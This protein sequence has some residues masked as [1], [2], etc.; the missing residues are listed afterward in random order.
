[1][2]YPQGA[3]ESSCHTLSNP[4]PHSHCSSA[5]VL[6]PVGFFHFGVSGQQIAAM[7]HAIKNAPKR[8][9]NALSEHLGVQNLPGGGGGGTSDHHVAKRGLRPR[10]SGIVIAFRSHHFNTF[11]PESCPRLAL[12]Q[13]LDPSPM[14]FRSTTR[15]VDSRERTAA[16]QWQAHSGYIP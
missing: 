8:A 2:F 11:A 16:A 12:A 7:V 13:I 4:V 14:G 9:E 10:E 6:T 1:M 15:R 3:P 5:S